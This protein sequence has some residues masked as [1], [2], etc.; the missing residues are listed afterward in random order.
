MSNWVYVN[1]VIRIDGITDKGLKKIYGL[2]TDKELEKFLGNSNNWKHKFI[3]KTEHLQMDNREGIK[4]LVKSLQKPTGS[5]GG[6]EHKVCFYE[7]N[8]KIWGNDSS[9]MSTRDYNLKTGELIPFGYSID[10]SDEEY[11]KDGWK[12]VWFEH[13]GSRFVICIFGNLRDRDMKT[14]KKEFEKFLLDIQKYFNLEDISLTANESWSGELFRWYY[15][16]ECI[17]DYE[18]LRRKENENN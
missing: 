6:V 5:E 15:T 11:E 13:R 12:N 10:I 18:I 1:G 16:D 8:Y 17:V 7:E 4:K 2:K 3:L 14:F 9:S